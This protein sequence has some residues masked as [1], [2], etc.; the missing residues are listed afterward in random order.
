MAN[1]KNG[2]TTYDEDLLVLGHE[3]AD[4]VG[5]REL[6]GAQGEGHEEVVVHEVVAAQGDEH[7]RA[8]H[9]LTRACRPDQRRQLALVLPEVGQLP[10]HPQDVHELNAGVVEDPD[11]GRRE[12]GADKQLLA[13]ELGAQIR[14][15]GLRAQ[16]LACDEE[17]SLGCQPSS[18]AYMYP[19]NSR[20]GAAIYGAHRPRKTY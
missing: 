2:R 15:R 17:D 19:K 10:A 11:A 6:A 12:V 9:H 13:A 3:V 20:A 8:A 1:K 16:V 14:Q 18:A 5:Q 7:Q 4:V